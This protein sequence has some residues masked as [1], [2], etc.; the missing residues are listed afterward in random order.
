MLHS[1][2]ASDSCT[3]VKI[4][5]DIIQSWFNLSHW[6]QHICPIVE[7][8]FLSYRWDI[9]GQDLSA[10]QANLIQ[11]VVYKKTLK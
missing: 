2:V 8:W 1:I 9:I 11:A 4:N 10:L 3:K 5:I 7:G 6:A